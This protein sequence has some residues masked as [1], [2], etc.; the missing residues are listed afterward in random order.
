MGR[1]APEGVDAAF[2]CYGGDAV[3]VS[4]QVLKDPARV[5]SVADLTVV[6]QGGHLVWARANADELTELVDLAESGTLSVTVNRSYP[7]EQAAGAWRALQEEGRTRGRIVL[8][9]DAT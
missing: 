1:L 7:L 2:D 8:D 5:V 4:Q 3:A 9:I 6:D